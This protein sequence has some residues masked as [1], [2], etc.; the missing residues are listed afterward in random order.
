MPFKREVEKTTMW[1]MRPMKL[2]QAGD[3]AS[4]AQRFISKNYMLLASHMIKINEM[5]ER[6]VATFI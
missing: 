4:V 3:N 6:H 5:I 1:L 2:R